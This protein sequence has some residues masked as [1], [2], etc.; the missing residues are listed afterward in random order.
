MSDD[1]KP[2]KR[3]FS[4]LTPEMIEKQFKPGQSGNPGGRPP[5]PEEIKRL[6]KLTKK[7]F[8]DIA[9][10]VIKGSWDEL[11]KIAKDKSE[12]VLR[13]KLARGILNETYKTFDEILSRIIGKT[14]EEIKL[15]RPK[16][17]IRRLDGTEVVY[18]IDEGDEE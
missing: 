11:E 13:V 16:K 9:E 1:K 7:E 8:A 4:K 10:M 6:R 5:L 18:S 15:T 17:I 14:V 3:Q 2:D 12:T